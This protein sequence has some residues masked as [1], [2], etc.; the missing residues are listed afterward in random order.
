M[1]L[2]LPND[3]IIKSGPSSEYIFK[4][5]TLHVCS[6]LLIWTVFFISFSYIFFLK[7]EGEESHAHMS[8]MHVQN[9][10]TFHIYSQLAYAS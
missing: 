9:V 8:G 1:C 2:W 6:G 4:Q 10:C 5:F 7:K 3:K